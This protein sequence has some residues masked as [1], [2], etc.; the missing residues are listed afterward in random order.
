MASL[1][2]VSGSRAPCPVLRIP[3]AWL[4]RARAHAQFGR[5]RKFRLGW[6]VAKSCPPP[7]LVLFR[8]VVPHLKLGVVRSYFAHGIGFPSHVPLEGT[9]PCPDLF[10]L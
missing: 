9:G 10:G 8:L 6:Q 2:E 1:S 4:L 3:R 7:G 5:E